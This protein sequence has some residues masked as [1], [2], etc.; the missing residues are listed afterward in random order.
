[1]NSDTFLKIN[2]TE[3]PVV[4][5]HKFL[6]LIFNSKLSF[7]LHLKQLRVKC[8]KIT[9]LMKVVAHTDWSADKKKI[10]K[11]IFDSNTNKT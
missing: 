8:N 6:S 11:I 7:I 4:Q 1:M 3:I 9:Q 2:D 10:T 5:Q